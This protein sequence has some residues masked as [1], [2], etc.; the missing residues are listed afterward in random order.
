MSQKNG[1]NGIVGMILGITAGVAAA[2][3]GGL[4]AFKVLS[5]IK[6][7][8]QETTMVSPN[9]KNYVTVTCGS[10]H[11][12]RGLTL[13][14]I[15]AENEADHCDF[16]FLVGKNAKISFNWVDE[17]NFKLFVGGDGK[18]QRIC[19]VYFGGEEIIMKLYM[20]KPEDNNA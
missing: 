19:D 6:S 5:E 18:L 9:E 4:A 11:F 8:S 13:V 20:S 7:D 3:A 16:S 14:K 15:K 17:D 2:T 10:S 12:A 1:T